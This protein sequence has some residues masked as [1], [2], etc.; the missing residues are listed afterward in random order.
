MLKIPKNKYIITYLSFVCGF[1]LIFLA[2]FVFAVALPPPLSGDAISPTVHSLDIAGGATDSDNNGVSIDN[3]GKMDIHTGTLTDSYNDPQYG[4]NIG[5][6]KGGLHVSAPYNPVAG[7]N[8][9]NIIPKNPDQYGRVGVEGRVII[10]NQTGAPSIMKG[11]VGYIQHAAT[12]GVFQE[13]EP[14]PANVPM[15]PYAFYTTGNTYLGDTVTIDGDIKNGTSAVTIAADATVS[16][17]MNV[18][19]NLETDVLNFSNIDNLDN[20][21][22]IGDPDAIVL[23]NASSSSYADFDIFNATRSCAPNAYLVGCSGY[24]TGANSYAPYRGA[25]PSS[26]LKGGS[27]TSYASVPPGA[28][29]FTLYSV[30]Y[31]FNLN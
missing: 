25:V 30:P 18:N 14:L 21:L 7:I 4:L 22:L 31:C 27:C 24:V 29:D 19:G 6:S 17:N 12:P 10:G 20:R 1:F 11:F 13:Y 8:D 3:D 16:G 5:S 23:D 15:T 9:V 28:S 2:Q 26:N